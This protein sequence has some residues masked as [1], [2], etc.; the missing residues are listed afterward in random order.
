MARVVVIGAGIGGLASAARLRALGHDVTVLEQAPQVGGKLGWRTLDGLDV[1]RF[2]FDTG[3]SMLTMPQVFRD[4]FA[5][6]GAPLGRRG[7]LEPL[8]PLAR[9]RFADGSIADAEELAAEPDWRR[10]MVRAERM[11]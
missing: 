8:A 11:W 5:A 9:Y 4:L 3:P 1:G 10:L 6:T 7:H 2:H